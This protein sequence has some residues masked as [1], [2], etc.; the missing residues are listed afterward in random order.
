MTSPVNYVDPT[1]HYFAKIDIAG[2]YNSG[3][4]V[5]VVPEPESRPDTTTGSSTG[6]GSGSASSSTGDN[7]LDS[8]EP[9]WDGYYIPTTQDIWALGY[10]ALG[11]EIGMSP[12]IT[13]E[14]Y[15]PKHLKGPKHLYTPKHLATN[16]QT[17]ISTSGVAW[18]MTGI[19]WALDMG[20]A[21]T[22]DSGNT[23]RQRL[24]KMGIDTLAVV[25][26]VAVAWGMAAGAVL[27]ASA[28]GGPTAI[29]GAIG[30]GLIIYY[31]AEATQ[32]WKDSQYERYKIN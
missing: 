24:Q 31:G 23:G 13:I 19:G 27:G 12:N 2:H 9:I 25:M 18:T 10:N 26:N 29:A 21:L 14:N 30:A 16:S 28:L 22:Y 4:S 5:V 17:T 11:M 32:D 7:W 1:G 3:S 6:S 15:D 8:T 20:N